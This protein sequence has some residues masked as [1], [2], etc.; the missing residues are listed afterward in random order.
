MKFVSVC[1]VLIATV[2]IY[3]QD[4]EEK[5]KIDIELENCLNDEF[6]HTTVAMMYCIDDALNAWDEELNRVYKELMTL[7]STDQKNVLRS[8]QKEWIKFRDL[9]Y[10]N[11][12]SIY[13]FEGTMWGQVRLLKMLNIVKDR[14]MTISDYLNAYK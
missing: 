8:A 13:D 4:T 7:L 9:E 10:N 1:F 12:N 6:N 5:H 2:T 14:T 3:A 11:I